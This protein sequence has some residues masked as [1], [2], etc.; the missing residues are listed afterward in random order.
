MPYPKG[1]EPQTFIP[2]YERKPEDFVE[3]VNAFR[4]PP[5]T[6][7]N[8][9]VTVQQEPS[10]YV[11][12]TPEEIMSSKLRHMDPVVN[13]A[14]HNYRAGRI[15]LVDALWMALKAVCEQKES[16]MREYIKYVHRNPPEPIITKEGHDEATY[17]DHHS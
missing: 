9:Y 5:G 12:V 3:G 14:L 15:P 8:Q 1:G 16:V 17:V 10:P 7:S 6:P 11:P 2:G 13:A 4:A